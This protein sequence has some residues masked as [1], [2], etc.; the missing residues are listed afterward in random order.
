[1]K[2]EQLPR[3]YWQGATNLALQPCS[4]RGGATMTSVIE[5]YDSSDK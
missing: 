3:Q 2:T 4:D 5:I 1:M